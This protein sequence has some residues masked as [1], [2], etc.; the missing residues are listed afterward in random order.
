MTSSGGWR[1]TTGVLIAWAAAASAGSAR[2]QV[3]SVG[4]RRVT[5]RIVE[6][7]T[8]RPLARALVD[9]PGRGVVFTDSLG[10]YRLRLPGGEDP[11][12]LVVGCPVERRAFGR[13]IRAVRIPLPAR[14][15]TL[16]D[17]TLPRGGCVEPPVE[18]RWGVFRGHHS[19]AFEESSFV[20]CEPFAD[21]AETAYGLGPD[22][23][24]AWVVFRDDGEWEWPDVP[25]SATRTTVYIEVRGTLTG[26]GGYG[27][28]GYSA[29]L[30][31]VEE[32]LEIREPGP[33]DCGGRGPPLRG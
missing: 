28:M 16:P 11:A 15:D 33:G 6:E 5:G 14:S 13:R 22:E 21:L 30:L 4:T 3:D 26:P 29:Y 27:H 7:G 9:G 19:S 32:V 2:A 24:E 8:R 20:P 10:R 18:T 25:S 1:W 12:R 31:E 17:V 23:A